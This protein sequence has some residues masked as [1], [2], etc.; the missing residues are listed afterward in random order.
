VEMRIGMKTRWITG[1]V[2]ALVM[3]NAAGL[4]AQTASELLQ[5]GI[6][7]QETVGDLDGAIKLYRQ[8]VD[9]AQQSRATDAQVLYRLGV[10]L[11]KKGQTM[12]AE[13]AFHQLIE[14]Y[15]E[16]TE[17]VASAQQ[18]LDGELKLLSAPW[19]DGEV[20]EYS[21]TMAGRDSGVVRLSIQT[22]KTNPGHW[23]IEERSLDPNLISA[24]RSE[25]DKETMKPVSDMYKG[26]G[27]GETTITYYNG[28]AVVESAGAAPQ[29]TPLNGREWASEE[30]WAAIR[31]WP[32]APGY[33]S[34][35]LVVTPSGGVLKVMLS[36]VGTED[37]E[38]PAGKFH[39]YKVQSSGLG[40]T[41]WYST[42]AA[43]YLVRRDGGRLSAKLKCVTTTRS[44]QGP[45]TYRN[46]ELGFSLS[47]PPGWMARSS[48]T[49]CSETCLV[50]LGYMDSSAMVT[51]RVGPRGDRP[52]TAE[53]IR[54]DAEKHSR[55]SATLRSNSWRSW[56]IDGHPALSWIEDSRSLTTGG[57]R[58]GYMVEI[59]SDALIARVEL[60]AETKDFDAFRAAFDP[61]LDTLK[62]K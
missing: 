9:L 36:V 16:Q 50:R 35:L 46:D 51:L 44:G 47:L 22:S 4:R 39:C 23:I 61:I 12:E 11:Q 48:S 19:T 54:T 21:Q 53:A 56:Q 52:A 24:G 2:L 34:S 55:L 33:E 58:I 62:L 59:R 26:F 49:R 18:A 27:T 3:A 30:V 41:F 17:L 40:W 28:G 60:Q 32:L 14:R 37:V 13:K 38:T 25:V 20:L 42:D 1:M 6:H 10:C 8:E 43:R 31:R 29:R 15:P 5:K 57:P 45:S 7:M